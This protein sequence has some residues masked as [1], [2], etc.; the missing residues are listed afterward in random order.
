MR[1]VR[2]IYKKGNDVYNWLLDGSAQ[3]L[4]TL[5][6]FEPQEARNSGLAIARR[7]VRLRKRRQLAAL[8]TDTA[9]ADRSEPS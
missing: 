7:A 1:R 8:E 3:F 4:M 5:F 6:R 2:S 9:A